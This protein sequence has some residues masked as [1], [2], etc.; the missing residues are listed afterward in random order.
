MDEQKLRM[1]LQ[2]IRVTY[3]AESKRLP[4]DALHSLRLRAA[5]IL[6]RI[7]AEA[8]GDARLLGEVAAIREEIGPE[9][10]G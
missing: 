6:E 2:I 3:R 9:D 4:A 5:V 1:Q 7:E 10:V 8:N